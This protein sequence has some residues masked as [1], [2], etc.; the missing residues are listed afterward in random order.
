MSSSDRAE[1]DGR[2]ISR[3]SGP[4]QKHTEGPESALVGRFHDLRGGHVVDV[5]EARSD[6]GATQRVPVEPEVEH[7]G[8]VL[9]ELALLGIQVGDAEPPRRLQ[10]AEELR[11]LSVDVRDVMKRHAGYDQVVRA[12]HLVARV[13]PPR[14]DVGDPCRSILAFSTSSMPCEL[15]TPVTVPTDA[16][17]CNVAMPVPHPKSSQVVSNRPAA[18]GDVAIGDVLKS[19]DAGRQH[20]VHDERRQPGHAWHDLSPYEASRAQHVRVHTPARCGADPQHL[21]GLQQ[22]AGR[23]HLDPPG[24][25]G[26]PAVRLQRD[27]IVGPTNPMATG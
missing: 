16:A 10:R 7:P 2:V 5:G 13:Q 19:R 23:R 11:Q 8:V 14:G 6:E 18:R 24:I 15:S 4:H 9:V 12:G 17:S 1:R 26:D 20:A 22:H 25:H 3:S 21:V 27:R